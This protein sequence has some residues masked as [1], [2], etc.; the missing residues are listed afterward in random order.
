MSTTPNFNWP[1]IAT[2]QA[3]PEVTHNAAME[4]IDAA[5]GGLFSK[6]LSDA[7]YTLNTAAVPSEAADLF[8]E[9]TGTLTAN[10]NIIV[11]ANKKAYAVWN[12]A[13]SPYT[14]TI[15]TA[16]GTGVAIP[17]SASEMSVRDVKS[18]G[19][20]ANRPSSLA[21]SRRK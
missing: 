2:N 19:F 4:L 12:N 14:L 21:S 13:T 18:A 11:P 17:Y 1:L 5:W 20:K 3:S 8:Y 10:R 16:S 7:D 6:V 15:K 9:F